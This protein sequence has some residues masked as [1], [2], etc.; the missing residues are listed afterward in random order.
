MIKSFEF[1][2]AKAVVISGDIHGEFTELVHRLCDRFHMTDTLLIVAGDCG[3]GF[4]KPGYYEHVYRRVHNKLMRSNNWVVM[5]RGNH[6]DPSY[7]NEEKICFDRFLCVPDYS[8]LKACK[9]QILC[10]GGAV[11]IDRSCRRVGIS[12]WENEQPLFDIE[13]LLELSLNYHIDTVVTHTSPSF[14]E[15]TTKSGLNYWLEK[16]PALS[17]DCQHERFEIDKV[18]NYL[19][20][21]NHPLSHWFYGHFHHSWASSIDG[22]LYCMLDIMEF[23]ELF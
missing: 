3:V 9:H 22:I 19:K 15:F 14:C 20:L 2:E 16:D 4:E 18:L 1:N 12:Y 17:A 21:N 11:S 7:F 10:V 23:K 6:D 8:V 5:V 13:K